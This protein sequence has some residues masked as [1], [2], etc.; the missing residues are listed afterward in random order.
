MKTKQVVVRGE[1]LTAASLNDVK[2]IQPQIG[3]IFGPT[4]AFEN[5]KFMQQLVAEKA[6]IQWIGCSTAGEIS[7]KG[8]TDN[9]VVITG[10]HFDNPK[11]AF[12]VATARIASPEKSHEAG[13]KI[14][15]ILAS[16]E[17]RGI[18]VIGPGVNVNGSLLVQGIVNAAPKV[19][20][21]GGLAA[22]GGK[23]QKTYT[24]SPEGV[25]HDHVVALGFY[26]DAVQMHSGCAGGWEAFGK[27]RRV[28]R[29]KLNVVYEFDEQPALNI[30]KEYLGE[31]AKNLPTSG[32]MFPFALLA[33]EH[34][35]TGLVR[36]VLSVD[37]AAGSLIFAGNVPQ[38][39]IVRLM[40]AKTSELVEGA[41]KAAENATSDGKTAG[42]LAI[43]VSCLGRRVVM[44]PNVDE[45]IE[46]IE[47]KFGS[48]C[49][50]AGFY[51]Y[52]EIGPFANKEE[53]LLHNQTMTI[54]YITEK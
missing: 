2:A 48:G 38:G 12:K 14:A 16:D 29:S 3:V 11:S 44:G 52:G 46:A 32:L 20:V 4:S 47:E 6:S 34:A 25:S 22:D 7:H 45:E 28:T 9:M 33:D 26:G 39:S 5:Q 41:R 50:V 36:T 21:T 17:L 54:S 31:H 40:H 13:E 30:F 23:Y 18:F 37:E 53:S 51:S 49:T 24:L 15:K 42:A 43:A 8:V 35:D 1:E 10:M 27:T 19:R